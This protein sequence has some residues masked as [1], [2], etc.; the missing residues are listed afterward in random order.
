MC[1]SPLTIFPSLTYA[2]RSHPASMSARQ[3]FIIIIIITATT[4]LS[5]L[6]PSK[7]SIMFVVLNYC[8]FLLHVAI[9]MQHVSA[10]LPYPHI[11]FIGASGFRAIIQ[12]LF[13]HIHDDRNANVLTDDHNIKNLQNIQR[14]ESKNSKPQRNLSSNT[15]S[16]TEQKYY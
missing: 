10:L 11:H 6:H 12:I 16:K 3:L 4:S 1:L 9:C 15:I 7:V 8:Q 5:C 14:S 2:K 13:I